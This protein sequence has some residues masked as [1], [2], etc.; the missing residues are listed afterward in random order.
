MRSDAISEHMAY[1]LREGSVMN[2]A[3]DPVSCCMLEDRGEGIVPT[4]RIMINMLRL[5]LNP[6][7]RRLSRIR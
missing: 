3:E 4:D 6:T 7:L 1:S 5:L 2:V